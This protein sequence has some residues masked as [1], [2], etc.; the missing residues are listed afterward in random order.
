M[1]R[2]PRLLMLLHGYYPDEPRVLAEA[3][4]AVDAGFEV[5]ILTLRRPGGQGVKDVDGVRCI[6]LPIQHRRGAGVAT[7][8]GEYLGF[9]LLATLK[10]ARLA[11][12]RYDVVQVHNPPDFLFVAAL[13]P[14]LLGA[15]IVFDVH[16]LASDMFA[17][18]FE[19]LPGAGVADRI[20]RLVERAAAASSSAVLTV[21]EPYRRELAARGIPLE[22]VTVVMNSLDERLLPPPEPSA[23]SQE[24]RVVYHGT[25]TPHYGV[26]LLVQ[27]AGLLRDRVANLRVEIYGEGDAVVQLRDD[28]RALGIEDD[29][30]ISGTY[31]PQRDVLRAVQ[32]AT[33]GVIPN[34]PNRL[35]RYALSTKL[36]EYVALGIPVVSADLPTIREHFSDDE[37]RYFRAGDAGSLADAL[38]AI[39]ADPAM[40]R[41]QAEAA[42]RRYE[43]YRWT[44]SKQAYIDVLRRVSDRAIP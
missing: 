6:E 26:A 44:R 13:V 23:S 7:V 24:C 37:V 34:L 2:R 21:H 28:A 41:A 4:A 16:D 10:A 1:A 15:R 40:A 43:H 11:R 8:L 3:T 27:A 22:K 33:V 35:N 17:M 9:T 12:R 36:L 42:L 18:R 38:A 19:R 31:L 39:A 32:G 29:V 5:D 30:Q 20:L 14:R 25:V